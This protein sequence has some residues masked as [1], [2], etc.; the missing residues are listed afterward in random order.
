MPTN[1]VAHV[2]LGHFVVRQVERFQP[3]TAQVAHQRRNLPLVL[4]LDANEHLRLVG[5]GDA[6]I[7]LGNVAP[8]QRGAEF[9]VTAGFLRNGHGEDGFAMFAHLGALGDESQAVEIGVGAARDGHHGL[10][11]HALSCDVGLG[12]GDGERARRLEDGA[13]V[14]EHV[15]DRRADL[16]GIDQDHVV[17]E[18]PANAEGFLADLLH[19]HA[20]GKQPHLRK[21]HAPAG[22]ERARHGIRID[23]LHADDFYF[24]AQAFDV[25]SDAG[26]Q[27]AAADGDENR[28]D[29]QGP[30]AQDFHAYC[31]LPGDHVGIVVRMHEGE[32]AHT[33][34]LQR[35]AVGLVVGIAEQHHLGAARRYR[36]HLD[37]RRRHRHHDYRLAAEFLRRQGHA[38]GV[39]AG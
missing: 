19:R 5:I 32:L 30:L 11:A 3:V 17:D 12:P 15:L 7:E 38:L 9:F 34:E 20:V 14:L 29:R 26:D 23:R 21:A 18:F 4:H 24:R 1:Q 36:I 16:V 25:G 33:L 27:P 35:M 28:V 22:L 31:A 6:V 2:Q 10:A 39:V 13:R 8:A 37:A